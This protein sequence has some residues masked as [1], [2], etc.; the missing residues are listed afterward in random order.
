[1]F[2]YKLC[3]SGQL[4]C[5]VTGA[6][7]HLTHNDF[8]PGKSN[9]FEGNYIGECDGFDLGDSSAIDLSNTIEIFHD[10]KFKY[11]NF[12]YLIYNMVM[13]FLN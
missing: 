3:G 12:M 11:F 5:C 10:G 9:T 4:Q 6:L 7:N 1:M 13:F 2:Y 8:Q